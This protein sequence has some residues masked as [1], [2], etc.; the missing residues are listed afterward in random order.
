[1]PQNLTTPDRLISNPMSKGFFEPNQYKCVLDRCNDGSDLLSL[2]VEINEELVKI[3]RKFSKSIGD[4]SD[5]SKRKILNSK[6]STTTKAAWKE[7]IG[8]MEKYAERNDAVANSI[9]QNVLKGLKTFQS[10]NYAKNLVHLKKTK[11]LEKQ[12][13]R[14]QAPWTEAIDKITAAKHAYHEAQRKLH[15]AAEVNE[16]ASS[17]LGSTDEQKQK[18]SNN[19]ARRQKEVDSCVQKHNSLIQDIDSKK[20][21]YKKDMEGVLAKAKEF[22]KERLEQFNATFDAIKKA[23]LIETNS[24]QTAIEKA[25]NDAIKLQNIETDIGEF[26]RMYGTGTTSKWPSFEQLKS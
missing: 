15:Q 12:F 2:N 3:L 9:D 16:C 24:F 1:M 6:E 11:D 21:T 22:E 14:A 23:V 5:R 19:V 20:E 4:W 25:F 8:A 7:S 17:D 13:K 26:N 10:K 18:A